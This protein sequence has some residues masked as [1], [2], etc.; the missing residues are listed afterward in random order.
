MVWRA[1]RW[2]S[3]YSV[4]EQHNHQIWTPLNHSG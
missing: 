2:I 1:W 4:A 3:I